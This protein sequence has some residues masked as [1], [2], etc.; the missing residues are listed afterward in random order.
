MKTVFDSTEISHI[1]FHGSA[2]HGK[3]PGN[4]S[5]EGDAFYSYG[6]VIGRK[7][8]HKGKRAVIINTTSFSVNTSK[9]FGRMC[10]AI[11]MDT[12]KFYV[13]QGM[14]ARLNF[15]GKEL[16]DYAVEKSAQF[17]KIAAQTKHKGKKERMEGSA[18]HWLDEAK[19]VVEF[20]GLKRKVDERTA[21][22]LATAK[23]RE[24]KRQERE[25]MA[26]EQ[27]AQKKAQD[28]YDSWK[29]GE[30]CAQSY[31]PSH[32]VAFR[33]E[34]NELVSSLGARV[35]IRAACIALRFVQS[36]KGQEWR[37]NGEQCPVD[38]YRVNAINTQGIV[39]GC[40]R[41]TWDEIGRV[42]GLIS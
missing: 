6:T 23:V 38:S 33:V 31:F 39:A 41:I 8:E 27:A 32:P 4:A 37:E 29:R 17:L 36:R 21:Q 3:S 14:G 25:R 7:I 12:P 18:A 34:G 1:W 24:E 16:F 42:A 19:R 40:H 28:N 30:A 15:G 13:E 26:R 9:V 35:S 22:R 11:P 2:P 10:A 5:F 20:F